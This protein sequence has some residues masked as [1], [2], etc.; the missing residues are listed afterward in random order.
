MGIRAAPKDDTGVSSAELVYG[1]GMVLL[2]ELQVPS[3]PIVDVALTPPPLPPSHDTRLGRR[4]RHR[5][6]KGRQPPV[7]LQQAAYMYV[8][9]GYCGKP[10]APVTAA[11]MRWWGVLHFNCIPG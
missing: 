10:L 7:P 8:R 6:G 9:R 1:C 4:Q 11:L 3:L 5:Q 2:G